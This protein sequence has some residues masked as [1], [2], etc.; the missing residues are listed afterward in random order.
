MLKTLWTLRSSIYLFSNSDHEVQICLSISRNLDLKLDTNPFAPIP[1]KNDRIPYL[2]APLCLFWDFLDKNTYVFAFLPASLKCFSLQK[3]N[4]RLSNC[5]SSH[6]MRFGGFG[7]LKTIWDIDSSLAASG[8]LLERISC[9][10]GHATHV[11]FLWWSETMNFLR[12]NL[13]QCLST[14]NDI[15]RLSYYLKIGIWNERTTAGCQ[16]RPSCRVLA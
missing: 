7:Y 13:L 12:F 3:P 2:Q 11:S 4:Q 16:L 14:I 15:R 1:Y 6:L 5:I 10:L 9:V 8:M